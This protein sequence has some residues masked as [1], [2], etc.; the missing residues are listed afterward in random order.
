MP[1]VNCVGG[2]VLFS[3]KVLQLKTSNERAKKV[4]LSK[5]FAGFIEIMTTNTKSALCSQST[6]SRYLQT[7]DTRMA[8]VTNLS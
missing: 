8:E 7:Q 2:L 1:P 5:Y 3:F 6:Y 4:S